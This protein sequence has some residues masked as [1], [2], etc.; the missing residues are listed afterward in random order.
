LKKRS[1]DPDW[2]G[3]G[4]ALP[5]NNITTCAAPVNPNVT[6]PPTAYAS[7]VDSKAIVARCGPLLVALDQHAADE[8]IQ[9][10]ALQ[11]QIARESSAA[12]G[13]D[14]RDAGS[15]DG[16][17]EGLLQTLPLNPPQVRGHAPSRSVGV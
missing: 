14:G 7:Q 12:L 10:E 15:L 16:S 3:F 11:A 6:A 17:G 5:I 4:A 8:R 2:D 13:G 9:L 1:A